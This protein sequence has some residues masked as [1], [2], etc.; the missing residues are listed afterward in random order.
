MCFNKKWHCGVGS[1]AEFKSHY[2][3][4]G[5]KGL[6][7]GSPHTVGMPC[8]QQLGFWAL[9]HWGWVLS[10]GG[11]FSSSLDQVGLLTMSS[12]WYLWVSVCGGWPSRGNGHKSH[13]GSVRNGASSLWASCMLAFWDSCGLGSGVVGW[14]GAQ[15]FPSRAGCSPSLSTGWQCLPSSAQPIPSQPASSVGMWNNP[16]GLWDAITPMSFWDVFN[17]ALWMH[18]RL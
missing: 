7:T 4:P 9:L 11:Y 1:T 13:L 12:L 5:V 16:P 10:V 15:Q 3:L 18:A 17:W 14:R 2:S 6:K 8:R